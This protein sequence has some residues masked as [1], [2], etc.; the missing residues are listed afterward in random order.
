MSTSVVQEFK[1]IDAGLSMG[2]VTLRVVDIDRSLRFYRDVLGFS[3]IDRDG[4]TVQ[5]GAGDRVLLELVETKSAMPRP[6]GTT[7]LYHVAILLPTRGDLG[8]ILARIVEAGIPLG[9]SDHLVSEA[10]YL[11]DP[12]GNGLELYRDRPRDQWKWRDG[13]VAMAVDPL[14][15]RALLAD[16]RNGEWK[17]LPEGTVVGHVHLNVADLKTA[18]EFYHGVLG[19][20]IVAKLPGAL[21]VS[22][23]GYHHHLGLNVWESRGGHVAPP[24]SVGLIQY[25]IELT[26]QAAVDSVLGRLKAAGVA[27]DE[28]DGAVEFG[29]PFGNKVSL[30]SRVAYADATS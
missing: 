8:R 17:G 20:D 9:Q 6:R 13:Q 12:D 19:F 25:T 21:F 30:Q 23:G 7:G 4:G 29:D 22:A 1:S 5:L 11:S 18:E 26:S 16:G 3:V 27:V 28:I 2:T 15:L 24:S 14:D 10:L